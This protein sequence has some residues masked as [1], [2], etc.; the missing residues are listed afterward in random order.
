MGFG[1]RLSEGE[2]NS[3]LST[4]VHS[5]QSLWHLLPLGIHLLDGKVLSSELPTCVVGARKFVN[6]LI[7]LYKG[8]NQRKEEKLSST[9]A[10]AR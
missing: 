2:Q 9:F 7:H 4:W 6:V 10:I 5:K 3:F 8:R 1:E